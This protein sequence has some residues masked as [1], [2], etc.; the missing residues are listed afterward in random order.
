MKSLEKVCCMVVVGAVL[1]S[2]WGCPKKTEVTVAPEAQ[3]EAAPAVQ[4]EREAE[5]RPEAAATV[6]EEKKDEHAAPVIAG[7]QPIY[8]D[9]DQ[10]FIRD[11]AR[12]VM[13]ANAEWLKANPNVKIR[14]EG[15][16]D[17]RGTREYNQALGQRRAAGAKRYL[18]DLGIA[19][20]RIS[21]VSYGKEKPSCTGQNEECWQKNRRDDLV[22]E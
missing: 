19:V 21:L 18:A 8:F 20:K 7:L 22:V 11:D 4:K 17:E 3:K 15:G 13:K 14:I 10:S 6:T 2:L 16:C 1:F 5:Q 9:F 12:S